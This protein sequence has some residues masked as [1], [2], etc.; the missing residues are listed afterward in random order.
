VDGSHVRWRRRQAAARRDPWRPTIQ[1]SAGRHRRIISATTAIN[2]P[3][4]CR[5]LHKCRRVPGRRVPVFAVREG[6]VAVDD[7]PQHGRG[8]EKRDDQRADAEVDHF[9]AEEHRG[10][11]AEHR[12]G[13]AVA[14]RSRSG[15][16]RSAARS[17]PEPGRHASAS[18]GQYLAGLDIRVLLH[19]G[20]RYGPCTPSSHIAIGNVSDRKYGRPGMAPVRGAST[21]VCPEQGIR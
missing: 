18:S 15:R 17:F 3:Q 1:Q 6:A 7:S 4:T 9:V 13:P 16:S 5:V 2:S 11:L 20:R 12:A 8:Q 21:V 10:E 14:S 19:Y